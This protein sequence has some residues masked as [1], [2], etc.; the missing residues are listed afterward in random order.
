MD[1]DENKEVSELVDNRMYFNASDNG[2]HGSRISMTARGGKSR[3]YLE[4][5]W[6]GNS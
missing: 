5:A 6:R 1:Y 2:H 3:W 4:S